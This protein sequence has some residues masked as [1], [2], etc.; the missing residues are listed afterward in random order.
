MRKVFTEQLVSTT[1]NKTTDIA[2]A[3]TATVYTRSFKLGFGDHFGISYKATSSSG[4]PDLKIELEQSFQEPATEGSQDDN[5]VQGENISDIETSLTTETM[6]HKEIVP[7]TLP[8]ARIKIT[9]NAA[10]PADTTIAI[11]ISKQEEF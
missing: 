10:N 1:D 7:V 2:V 9:G 4:T 8:Y 11:R 5:W 3:S 6:H